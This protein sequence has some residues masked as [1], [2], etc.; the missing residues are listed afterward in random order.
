M[1]II[2]VKTNIIT[3]VKPPKNYEVVCINDESLRVTTSDIHAKK[4]LSVKLLK[5]VEKKE[6]EKCV[7]Q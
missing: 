7:N 3:V 1:T 5:L 4:L 2:Q 6:K